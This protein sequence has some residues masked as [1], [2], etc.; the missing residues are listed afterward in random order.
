MIIVTN[1]AL[2]HWQGRCKQWV[3]EDLS[4]KRRVQKAHVQ[5]VVESG[6]M[7][8]RQEA[9][10]ISLWIGRA[11]S[12][13]WSVGRRLSESQCIIVE[14]YGVAFTLAFNGNDVTVITAVPWRDVQRYARGLQGSKVKAT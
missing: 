1:H 4:E 9:R 7:A 13:T 6:R 5:A 12:W 2:N 10:M 11:K 8:T 3:P 14:E